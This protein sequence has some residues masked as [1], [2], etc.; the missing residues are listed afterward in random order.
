MHYI[1][2]KSSYLVATEVARLV[3]ALI[4]LCAEGWMFES[5]SQHTVRSWWALGDVLKNVCLLSKRLKAALA[6]KFCLFSHLQN[7]CTWKL[8]NINMF[9]GVFSSGTQL[10]S[11]STLTIDIGFSLIHPINIFICLQANTYWYPV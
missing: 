6:V 4:D 7:L 5:R 1:F 10:K 3:K 9:S 8:N 11:C 2:L